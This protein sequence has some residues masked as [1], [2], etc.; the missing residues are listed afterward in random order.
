MQEQIQ[1]PNYSPAV[2]NLQRYL[3][4]LAYSEPD[5][6][7]VPV[8][9]IFDT[10]TRDALQNYQRMAGLP[11]TG[12]ADR[13]TWERLYADYLSSLARNAP[14]TPISLFPRN[15]IGGFLDVGAVGIDVAVLQYMLGELTLLYPITPP[16]V[17]GTY[18]AT[19]AEDVRDMQGYLGLTQNGLVDILT[20]N[21]IANRFNALPAGSETQ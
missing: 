5:I 10:A 15:P 17:T 20:W 8:D 13:T 21:A 18:D 1:H 3:R 14:P 9:G 16:T 6:G 7:Q 12:T 11:V 2:A 19:T 4:Q